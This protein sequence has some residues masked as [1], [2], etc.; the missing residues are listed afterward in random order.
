M[1]RI[2]QTTNDELDALKQ[3]LD[4]SLIAENFTNEREIFNEV[5]SRKSQVGKLNE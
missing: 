5:K 4:I 2:K 3:H 1:A